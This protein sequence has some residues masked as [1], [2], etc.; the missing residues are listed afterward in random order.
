MKN[1]ISIALVLLLSASAFAQKDKRLK[2]IEKDLN[3]LLKTTKAA[4]FSVAVVENDKVVW[5]SGFGYRDYENKIPA[6]ANT[7]FAIGSSTKAF[8]S[9]LLGQLRNEGK[10]AFSDSPLKYIPELK[11][12]NNDLNGN[13]N[14]EDLMSH[15]TGIPRHDYSWYLFPTHNRDSLIQKIQYHEPFAGLREQWHYN[16]YMFAVQGVIAEKLTGKSW[17]DNIRERILVP[18]G[19]TRSNVSIAEMKTASN[20]S[21]GYSLDN[22]EAITKVDYY[23]IAA[24]APAGSINSSANDMANWLITWINKGSFKGKELLP[25]AYVSEAMSSHAVVS[26]NLPGK[27]FPMSFMSNYGY[28]WMMASYKGHYRVEHGGNIDGFSASVAFFPAENIGIVVLTNQ[29]SS[30]LTS[31]VRNTIS[32]RMLGVE[33][34]DWNA[35]MKEQQKKEKE[36]AE[37]AKKATEKKEDAKPNA[38]PSHPLDDYTG[39]FNNP[40]YGTFE[41]EKKNDS[42]FALFKQTKF[43]L[44]HK[45]YDIFAPYDAKDGIDTSEDTNGLFMN[46]STNDAGEISGVKLKIEQSL[47]HPIEFKR[48]PKEIKVET[49]ILK[50]YEGNYE[51]AGMSLKVSVKDSKLYILVPGQPEYELAAIS[52]NMY[53]LTSLDGYKAEFVSAEDGRVKEVIL[54]QPNGKFTAIKK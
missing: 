41:I 31:L 28:G 33:R 30:A 11:F 3:E 35:K 21:F 44:K 37:E 50:K 12:Y 9:S 6:D 26:G 8:T 24:M 51:I 32:D 54:H 52:N 47:D 45:H 39:L 7:L 46:F 23:D 10:L 14:I 20:A 48:K 19:M 4:G 27:D 13:I 5:S 22:K 42:L 29:N 40:G 25:P 15:R 36:A 49:D 2:N 53:V 1:Y 34:T 43:Y 38:G 18:L 16:N 17:E